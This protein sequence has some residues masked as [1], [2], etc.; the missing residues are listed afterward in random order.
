M[1]LGKSASIL[2]SV[3]D[4]NLPKKGLAYLIKNSLPSGVSKV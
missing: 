1:F 3:S 2:I 4:E